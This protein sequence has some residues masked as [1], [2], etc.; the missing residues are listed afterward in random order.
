MVRRSD[1]QRSQARLIL[2]ESDTNIGPC[3][4]VCDPFVGNW[5]SLFQVR[6]AT[7]FNVLRVPFVVGAFSGTAA[8][9]LSYWLE[10]TDVDDG[11]LHRGF[12]GNAFSAFFALLGFLSVFRTNQAYSRFWEGTG[13]LN[14]IIGD[15]VDATS[16]L[17]AFCRHSK[18]EEELTRSFQQRI[19]RIVSLLNAMV[20][21]E[22]E[23]GTAEVKHA[24]QW[25]L[26]DIS[27]LDRKSL[28]WLAKAR[29]KPEVV[30]QWLQNDLVDA[31]ST[32]VLSI[33]PPLLTRVFVEYSAGMTKY[34][35]ALKF[36]TVPLPAPYHTLVDI[37]LAAHALVAPLVCVNWS[38]HPVWAAMFTFLLVFT[39]GS[40]NTISRSL[41]NP[42]GLDVNCL[43]TGEIQYELNQHL[44]TIINNADSTVHLAFT[45]GEANSRIQRQFQWKKSGS[46]PDE[47]PLKT[48]WASLHLPVRKPTMSVRSWALRL[49]GK[50]T[51]HDD[52]SVSDLQEERLDTVFTESE[53]PTTVHCTPCSAATGDFPLDGDATGTCV[54]SS[55]G[56]PSPDS[57]VVA[58]SVLS[59][60]R[61][62]SEN[63]CV[64]QQVREVRVTIDDA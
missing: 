26:L 35:E 61:A 38:D 42:Y 40:M 10:D 16:T 39:V 53:T 29:N 30:F 46:F 25:Q 18:A 49:R 62:V 8:A 21:G 44:M 5:W 34:H 59:P 13:L 9:I 1:V 57:G 4:V 32:G 28:E 56:I 45:S 6:L 14:Q 17:I 54:Q 52:E 15:W 37:L 58:G 11:F 55:R 12:E 19:I 36:A 60:T 23:G 24:V 3:P 48:S 20:L 41:E 22:L 51:E 7:R 47:V 50:E 33:P 63:L 43:E 27:G 2:T 31:V 64:L